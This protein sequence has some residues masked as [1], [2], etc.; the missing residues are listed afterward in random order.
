MKLNLRRRND[1]SD[2][3]SINFIDYYYG[4]AWCFI[5]SHLHSKR[6]PV[7]VR[8]YHFK[9]FFKHQRMSIIEN[10][11]TEYKHIKFAEIFIIFKHDYLN[12]LKRNIKL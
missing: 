9:S 12:A 7:N 2:A 4:S 8:I 6:W 11:Y 3:V 10:D 1:T 5:Y